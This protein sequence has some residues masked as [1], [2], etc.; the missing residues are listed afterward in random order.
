MS[1]RQQQ[2]QGRSTGD[3]K[4]IKGRDFA[5]TQIAADQEEQTRSRR[6]E[7]RNTDESG[8]SSTADD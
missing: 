6:S 8:E 4:Q 5:G 3:E 2:H 7:P 1:R